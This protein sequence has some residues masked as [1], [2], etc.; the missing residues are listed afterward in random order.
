[1]SRTGAPSASKAPLCEEFSSV[2]TA[3]T[4][5]ASPPLSSATRLPISQSEMPW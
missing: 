2:L 1:M 3:R 4:L 5:R